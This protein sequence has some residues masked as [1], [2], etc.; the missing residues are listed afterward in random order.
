M[1][2][3]DNFIIAGN[4]VDYYFGSFDLFKPLGR[5]ILY[6][7]GSVAGGSF[8]IGF[9]GFFDAFFDFFKPT[10]Q[11][12][13]HA[14]CCSNYFG[15]IYDFFDI[16]RHDAMGY[17]NLTGLPYCNAARFC[18]FLSV[19]TPLFGGSQSI[20]R[21]ILVLFRYLDSQVTYF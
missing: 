6:H 16:V 11:N 13:W 15:G 10:S 7:W 12:N 1:F 17:I 14:N 9:F 21:V 8:I 3:I 20:S 4:G 18:D 19:N 2:K 5:L